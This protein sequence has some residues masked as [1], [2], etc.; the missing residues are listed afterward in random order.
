MTKR[1]I[2]LKIHTH[3][4]KIKNLSA[5]GLNFRAGW[6]D[7]HPNFRN[8]IEKNHEGGRLPPGKILSFPEIFVFMKQNS[9]F[10]KKIV[11]FCITL[12]NFLVSVVISYCRSDGVEC[13][14]IF[15]RFYVELISVRSK[16]LDLVAEYHIFFSFWRGKSVFEQNHRGFKNYQFRKKFIFW[17]LVAKISNFADIRQNNVFMQK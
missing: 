7:S 14:V 5:Q 3:T 12:D 6:W 10:L 15:F 2:Y 9:L 17:Q 1:C 8:P 11:D 16:N 13:G 4:K